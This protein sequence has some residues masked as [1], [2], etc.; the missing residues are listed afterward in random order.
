MIRRS[1]GAPLWIRRGWAWAHGDYHTRVGIVARDFGFRSRM[2][3]QDLPEK[4]DP[5]NS[6]RPLA[7]WSRAG[8]TGDEADA[9]ILDLTPR[10]ID[11]TPWPNCP[12]KPA[13]PFPRP[14]TGILRQ[15]IQGFSSD[16]PNRPKKYDPKR[17]PLNLNVVSGRGT[18]RP[19]RRKKLGTSCSHHTECLS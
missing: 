4:F 13:D 19:N 17:P 15:P 6:A 14:R 12:M 10:P 7:S 1:P 18:D 16:A 2:V 8:V 5:R 3:I 9:T 11:L